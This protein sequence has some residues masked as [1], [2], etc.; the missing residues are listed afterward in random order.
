M[1]SHF[2]FQRVIGHGVTSQTID[3]ICR[4]P[5]P[6][7]NKRD[8]NNVWEDLVPHLLGVKQS[9]TLFLRC[10]YREKLMTKNKQNPCRKK[11][12]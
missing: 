1:K 5:L 12:G 10:H 11:V 6:T 9:V 2:L 3:Q 4:V 7:I 8:S